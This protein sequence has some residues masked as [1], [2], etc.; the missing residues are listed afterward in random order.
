MGEGQV[1]IAA[2]NRVHPMPGLAHDARHR[3]EAKIV[4]VLGLKERKKERK[5]VTCRISK[6]RH[7]K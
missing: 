6:A 5:K 1:D 3:R 4:N 7:Q 2:A